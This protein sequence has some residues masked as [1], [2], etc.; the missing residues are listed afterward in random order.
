MKNWAVNKRNGIREEVLRIAINDATEAEA[1]EILELYGFTVV[2]VNNT[3]NI[4]TVI[5]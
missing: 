4:I 3:L 5:S 1:R 2:N